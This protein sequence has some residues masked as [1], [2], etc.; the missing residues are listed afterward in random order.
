[1]RR[2][3]LGERVSVLDPLPPDGLVEALG[4]YDLGIVFDRPATRNS[5]LS[6]P[7][8]LFEYL[9]AGLAVVVP[10][11]EALGPLVEG[12]RLGL[13]YAPGKP[14]ALAEAL[15]RLATDGDLLRELR[16]NARRLAL[17]RY[18][19]EAQADTLARAWGL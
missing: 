1:M 7:N 16:A 3:G 10:R 19:A 12:E 13:A 9:M 2:R 15:E 18:N 4:S 8:K 11:L 5:E 17:E 6:L 14:E